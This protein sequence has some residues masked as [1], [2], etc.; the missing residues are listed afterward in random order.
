[1]KYVSLVV[2]GI[3]SFIFVIALIVVVSIEVLLRKTRVLPRI[4]D[5]FQ[6]LIWKEFK[7]E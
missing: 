2:G 4:E 5:E 6:S 1:M 3:V 7:P